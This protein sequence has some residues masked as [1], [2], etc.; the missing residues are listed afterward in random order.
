MSHPSA[1]P[2]PAASP[3]L[4]R[5]REL[6]ALA[7]AL[8]YAA[9]GDGC[10]VVIEGPAGIGKSVLLGAVRVHEGGTRVLSARASELE[11]G[12]PFGVVRQIFEASLARP[13]ER[14]ALLSGAAAPAAAVFEGLGG[15]QAGEGDASFAVLHG[16]YWLTL[17]LS[18]RGPLVVAVDDLHWCDH[19]SLR[20]LAYLV[21]RLQ[22]LPVALVTTLRTSE[23]GTDAG[24][25][26]DIVHDPLTTILRPGALSADAVAGII[27]GRLGAEPDPAF[28]RAC[29]AATGGNPLL[30]RQLLAALAADGVEPTAG[31]AAA[32]GDI[33]PRAVSRTVLP[34]IA[35]AHGDAIRL[36]RAL[37]VLGDGA[38]SSS[39]S[40]LSG[41][42]DR[43]VGA[44]ARELVRLDIVEPEAPVRFI[45]PLVREAV[46]RDLTPAERAAAHE[47]AAGVLRAE[48]APPEQ[49][50]AQLMLTPPRGEPWVARLLLDTGRAAVRRGA[51]DAAV[52]YMRRA[53]AEPPASDER[54]MALVEMG[55]VEYMTDAASALEHLRQAWEE[56][57]SPALRVAAAGAYTR[58]L[59]LSGEAQLAGMVAERTRRDLPAEM[60][61]ERLQMLTCQALA[62]FFGSGDMGV[63]EELRAHRR[64][65]DPATSVGHLMVGAMAAL[66][67][68]FTDGDATSA[69]ALTRAVL[70][71]GRLLAADGPILGVVAAL[72]LVLSDQDDAM[73][74]YDALRDTAHRTGSLLLVATVHLWR[75]WALCQR[76]ALEEAEADLRLSHEHFLRWEQPPAAL[77]HVDSLPARTPARGAEATSRSF[78]SRAH[79]VSFL[80][81]TLVDRGHLSAAR[82][83]LVGM[84]RPAL[85]TNGG[86][87]WRS[88]HTALLLAEG[89]A[90]DALAAA[91][92]LRDHCAVLP[93]GARLHWR[94]YA[95]EALDR[96]GRTEEACAV[97]LEELEAA[98]AWGAAGTIGRTLRVL[99]TIE[100]DAGIDRLRD[101]EALLASTPSRLEHVRAQAALGAALRRGRRVAEAR[102]YLRRALAGA[103]AC[104]ANGLAE[105]VRTELQAAGVR[106]R[107]DAVE[108]VDALTP[109]ELR[110]ARMAAEG[111]TNKEIAQALYVTP[112]TVEVH[113]GS[114]YRKLGVR[115]RRDLPVALA[116][117]PSAP[118]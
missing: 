35:R 55:A 81:Q 41:L 116:P 74:V 31:G 96:M 42:D 6:A 98:R 21:R 39:L 8:R 24:L 65:P 56:A 58:A 19:D 77:G 107:T 87:H 11:R 80:A 32:I 83:A 20:F 12:F 93:D 60:A 9:A 85:G 84:P 14:D 46:Y 36:A 103:R 29:H 72:V 44:A 17:N 113:L 51:P 69:S 105:T 114:V 106:P 112:K 108:G 33:G 88:A 66:H 5:E 7:S 100:R 45:H 91:E 53:F 54:A 99:G 34:R 94:S 117:E 4:E 18:E 110:V 75:G 118:A 38:A 2:R 78:L 90:E 25:V 64:P 109:S 26:A 61:D 82:A 13:D 79:V 68:A 70:V 97:A 23:P 30:L 104:G 86:G 43:A 47:R 57:S 27:V 101:A 1:D 62:V 95:A 3:P 37:A 59:M 10:C 115:S 40:A 52:A 28:S 73:D 15:V 48:D 89:R 67:M 71:D 92:D 50:A 102:E 63:L 22:D 16:L 49:V 76:G 111:E